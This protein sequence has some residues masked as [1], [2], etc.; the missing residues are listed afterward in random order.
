M[1]DWRQPRKQDAAWLDKAMADPKAT[2]SVKFGR[3][4]PRQWLRY[5]EYQPRIK[6]DGNDYTFTFGDDILN[7]FD[8]RDATIKIRRKKDGKPVL[9]YW[10]PL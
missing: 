5:G 1:S 9:G 6:K 7:W 3:Y 10:Q 4:A 2:I 8:L